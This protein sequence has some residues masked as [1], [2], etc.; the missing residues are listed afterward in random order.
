M[1]TGLDRLVAARC[2]ADRTRADLV[3][4]LTQA[5]D[6]RRRDLLWLVLALLQ[7][8]L[9][10]SDELDLAWWRLLLDGPEGVLST[11]PTGGPEVE[12]VTGELLVDVHHTAVN[13]TRNGIQRVVRETVPRWVREHPLRLV[14]WEAGWAGLRHLT[15]QEQA[16]FTGVPARTGRL[17][18]WRTNLVLTEIAG[19]PERADRLR[20]MAAAGAV[21]IRA[22]VYDLV[23]VT[24]ADTTDPAM[25]GPFALYLGVLK[26]AAAVVTISCATQVEMLGYRDMLAAQSLD[27]PDV[28]EV[29]LP[30]E[31]RQSTPEGERAL[32]CLVADDVPLVLCVGTHEPRK[33]H[34][35]V[36]QAAELLWR[37]DVRLS[38]LFL[39]SSGWGSAPFTAKVQELER[40]GHPLRVVTAAQESLLWAAYRAARVL[41]FP[42]LHEG[43]GLPVAEA[44]AC[45]TP[46][47]TSAIGSMAE[48]ARDGGA[49]LV[50]PNDD[51]ALAAA[52][53]SV[54]EDDGLHARL[55]AEAATRPSR[56]WDDYA[57]ATFTALT[58]PPRA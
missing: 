56:T 16:P 38:L 11:A 35:A 12:V 45:G 57:R 26:H 49:L 15:T 37:D 55:A 41:V 4:V 21:S 29:A 3:L 13:P 40:A 48:L 2:N 10:L 46:V 54:L 32:R 23:P 34:L 18:P 39:G 31:A 9:P 33:N 27:G 47:I 53:R 50:D 6:G 19:E 42:S 51:E 44:L 30:A 58:G 25:P 5:R 24:A 52:L 20:A 28:V 14:A 8:E 1:I 7:P 17:I 36:L 22:I 43:F